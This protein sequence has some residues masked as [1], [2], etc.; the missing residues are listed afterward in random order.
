MSPPSVSFSDP[1]STHH[2]SRDRRAFVDGE[3]IRG[4]TNGDDAVYE[5]EYFI[6]AN[7]GVGAWAARPRGHAGLWSRLILHFWASAIESESQ[8]HEAA[9]LDGTFQPDPVKSLQ[10][11]FERTTEA[12]TT[13]DWQGTTTACGAQL[14]YRVPEKDNKDVDPMPQL[15]VTNLGDCQIMVVRPRDRSVVFKTKEQWHWFD[16]P[17]QLGTNSPDTPN[18]SAVMDKVDIEVGDVVLA[19]S[20]GLIDNLWEH[21]IVQVV[22]DSIRNWE[23]GGVGSEESTRSGGRNGGMAS[24]A[25]DLVAAAK[26]IATDPFAESPYMEH[27]IEEGLASEG[28]KLDDISVVA[29][30][31][32][33]NTI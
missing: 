3:L 14:H 21:E 15:Y 13:H 7:D 11:A 31:C 26:V 30:L 12:T 8:T 24:A 16:C 2:N 29:A 5:S 23:Q 28:G 27:A 10:T 20:D 32:V 22:I 25:Q 17:R 9:V 18:D 19:M 4:Y 6:C 33:E 1:L